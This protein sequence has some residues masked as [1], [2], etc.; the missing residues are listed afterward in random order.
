MN[1]TQ[2]WGVSSAGRAPALQAGGHRFDPGTLHQQKSWQLTVDSWQL[3]VKELTEVPWKWD[4]IEFL[5]RETQNAPWKL[6]I[7]SIMMQ[8][9]E[10]QLREIFYNW[11]IIIQFCKY[12]LLMSL[13]NS[14]NLR[15]NIGL[16]SVSWTDHP[17]GRIL[18]DWGQAN[19]SARGM[20]WH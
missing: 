12:L 7:E 2:I 4:F 14:T 18:V 3:T 10:Q 9:W 11:V 19:K 6:N 5:E 13:H 8:L 15:T 17:G 20:P 1:S 16:F